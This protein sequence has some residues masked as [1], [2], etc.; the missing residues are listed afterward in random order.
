MNELAERV[1]VALEL[2]GDNGAHDSIRVLSLRSGSL[3]A[4]QLD[5]SIPVALALHANW[6]AVASAE[7]TVVR[8]VG[9]LTITAPAITEEPTWA[10][11]FSHGE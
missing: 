10:V 4:E 9:A 8:D 6:L 1:V 2:H 7:G 5:D 11:A 3:I